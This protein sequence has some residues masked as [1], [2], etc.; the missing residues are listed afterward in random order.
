[1]LLT[2]PTISISFLRKNN[3]KSNL[4]KTFSAQK[5]KQSQSRVFLLRPGGGM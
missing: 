3:G 4:M 1:M 2:I 5:E